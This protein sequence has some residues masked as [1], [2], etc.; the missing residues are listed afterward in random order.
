MHLVSLILNPDLNT[1]CTKFITNHDTCCFSLDTWKSF[2][3]VLCCEISSLFY[4]FQMW[5]FL[6]ICVAFLRIL[7]S[8]L[9]GWLVHSFV[10]SKPPGRI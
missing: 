4:I 5:I 2:G 7:G 1:F 8:L 9:L 6:M 10:H 3:V